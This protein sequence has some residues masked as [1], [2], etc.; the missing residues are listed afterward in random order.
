[1]KDIS[2]S[3]WVT[4]ALILSAAAC[5]IAGKDDAAAWFGLAAIWAVFIL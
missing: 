4:I 1:V 5:A 3:A 2:E